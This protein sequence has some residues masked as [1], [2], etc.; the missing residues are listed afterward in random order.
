MDSNITIGEKYRK[1]V[2]I[3]NSILDSPLRKD[4][5]EFQAEL[6]DL[7]KEFNSIQLIV[8]SLSLFSDNETLDEINVNYIP[9]ANVYYYLGVLYSNYLLDK[10][11]KLDTDKLRFKSLNLT[12]S[13]NKYMHYLVQLQ[14]FHS[15]LSSAQDSR[16]NSFE[17]LYNPTDKEILATNGNPAAKRQE[18]IDN[19]KLEKS[20]N[21]KLDILSDYY[22]KDEDEDN[23]FNRF[24]EETIK[25]I[26]VDQLKLHSIYT[27]TNL[28]SLVM[29]IKVL[30][31][32][33]SPSSSQLDKPPPPKIEKPT[34]EN[35]Y[36]YTPRLESLPFKKKQIN[37]LISRQGKILQ[38][39]TITSNRQNIKDKV[40]G[41]GQVLPS[42][43]VEEYLDYELANGKMMK[44]EVKDVPREDES[45]GYDSDKELEKRLWDDWKDDN[46]KGSGNMKANIG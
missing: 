20:L 41:T 39:F 22:T 12:I 17:H 21:S 24:D 23:S 42:M 29:E 4:S 25:N 27:F 32:R 3:F 40:F 30:S 16:L 33:P 35:D 31:N 36:G 2:K 37:D 5:S 26:F 14:N 9:F 44:E 45:D 13:K 46:P 1:A 10:D 15:I 11:G 34:K 28:E 38:P 43:S 8:D 7:I 19:F 6:A 18:K